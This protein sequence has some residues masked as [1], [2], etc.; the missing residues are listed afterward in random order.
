VRIDQG[1]LST[2]SADGT[3]LLGLMGGDG[4]DDEESSEDDSEEEQEQEQEQEQEDRRSPSP[5]GGTAQPIR[6]LLRRM[7]PQGRIRNR[8]R[9][10]HRS[11]RASSSS[12]SSA[13]SA[14]SGEES[15]DD[16]SDAVATT[17]DPEELARVDGRSLHLWLSS[18]K[19]TA[20][21]RSGVEAI[22]ARF[23]DEEV[24]WADLLNPDF[25]LDHDA[26]LR[27]G[28]RKEGHR[29]TIL[30]GRKHLLV[31]QGAKGLVEPQIASFYK[32]R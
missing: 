2:R 9:Q 11:A 1:W 22:F 15:T 6:R 16:D 13:S 29:G 3:Q 12:E 24:E 32:R 19:P 26:L 21:W 31:K 23:E 7:A 30:V 10:T 8:A 14:S 28:V 20:R 25:G 18:L 5:T 4:S 17:V 27:M